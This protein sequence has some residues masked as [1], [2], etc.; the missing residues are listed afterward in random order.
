MRYA[1][2]TNA[3]LAALVVCVLAACGD[4]PLYTP[5]FAGSGFKVYCADVEVSGSENA[6]NPVLGMSVIG[7]V[8]VYNAGAF[9]PTDAGKLVSTF[10]SQ[11][12]AEGNATVWTLETVSID[13]TVSFTRTTGYPEFHYAAILESSRTV[14]ANS[15]APSTAAQVEILYTIY[16]AAGPYQVADPATAEVL[17]SARLVFGIVQ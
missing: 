14:F 8:K 5:E 3:L 11:N 7:G 16:N 10:L 9:T 2:I 6:C 12:L 17:D 1:R 4:S 15:V 13:N